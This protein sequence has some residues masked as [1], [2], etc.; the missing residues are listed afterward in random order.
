MIGL[1]YDIHRFTEGRPLVL[2]GV[3]IPHTHGLDGHSDADVL[4]HAIADAVLGTLGLP[5]IGHWFPPGDPACKDICSLKIL[6]KAAALIREQG[7]ELV[8]VDA[9]LIA[10]APKVLPHRPA[11]QEKIGQALGLA[12]ERVGIKATTNEMLG[13]IG[14]REGMAAMAVAQI[15]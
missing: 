2:G 5:D 3:E 10:E 1:G 14:R 9:T 15:R 8:N 11:M 13:A 7:F 6:E 4:C 12:P